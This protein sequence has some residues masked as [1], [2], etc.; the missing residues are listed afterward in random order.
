MPAVIRVFTWDAAPGKQAE[1]MGFVREAVP[2]WE[3]LGAKVRVFSNSLSGANSTSVSV[4]AEYPS[5]G[6]FGEASD[7]ILADS[8]ITALAAKLNV[9]QVGR[10]VSSTLSVEVPMR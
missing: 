10:L 5:M 6:A 7:K 3:R 8:D 2:H 4:V 1:M 9:A